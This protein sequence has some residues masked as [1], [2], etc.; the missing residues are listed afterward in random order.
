MLAR[1]R[2]GKEGVGAVEVVFNCSLEGLAGTGTRGCRILD[3]ADESCAYDFAERSGLLSG[4]SGSLIE[5]GSGGA[6]RSERK[7]E[8]RFEREA[9][10]RGEAEVDVVM[11]TIS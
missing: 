4:D 1:V 7:S 8:R 3:C 11:A 6:R 2:E 10:F 9:A 5:A